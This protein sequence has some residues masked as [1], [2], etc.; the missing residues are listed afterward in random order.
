MAFLDRFRSSPRRRSPG[1]PTPPV[2]H[3]RFELTVVPEPG[4][5]EGWGLWIYGA[6]CGSPE[7][8]G[9]PLMIRLTDLQTGRHVDES[10]GPW[11][12][13]ADTRYAAIEAELRALDPTDIARLFPT[14]G[15]RYRSVRPVP[16]T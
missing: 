2:I 9:R 4:F 12:R 3:N 15:P 16:P 7:G 13:L 14:G 6:L 8:Q 11:G 10:V 5:T 1:R